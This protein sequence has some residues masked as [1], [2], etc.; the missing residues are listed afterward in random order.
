MTS[1]EAI[2]TR[3]NDL[4]GREHAVSGVDE[5]S[6]NDVRRK[7][8]VFCFDCPLHLDDAVAA[9]HGF[10][11]A[12]APSAMIPLW[13]MP[14]YW[15][16]GEPGLYGPGKP[17]S[18]GGMQEVLPVVYSSGVN[19]G[20]QVEFF[21]PVY[22]GD[23]LRSVVKLVDV[24][25]KQTRLGKGV[26][27][28]VETTVSKLGG[29]RVAVRRNTSYRYN[30]NPDRKT[31]PSKAKSNPGDDAPP[32]E[33]GLPESAAGNEP[34][35]WSRQLRY[36]EVAPGQELPGHSLWLSYQ[37]IV[38]SVAVDRMFSG[39]H[40]NR[41]YARSVG[42]AD[43]I[44]NTRGYEMAL[45][46]TMRR[47]M[48]YAGRLVKFGPFK[49]VSNSHPGDTLVFGGRVTG[50]EIVDGERRVS[51][52]VWADSPRRRAAEGAAVVALPD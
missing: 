36:S 7:L 43:I 49:M 35:D 25:P 41:D 9:A 19:A 47:W 42:L 20:S 28:T 21:E 52:D 34:V 37:R 33:S 14:A 5:V 16:P 29:E 2:L 39:I 38:M 48:G 1:D 46:I 4:I 23:R 27:L 32:R 8:E 50:M 40:H 10:R 26:F 6:R 51:L 12:P 18:N 13:A 3:L 22:P 31:D 24:K 44:F 45:E 11:M 15:T 17:E 30:A